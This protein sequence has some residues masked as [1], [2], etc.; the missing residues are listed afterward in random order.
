MPHWSTY[1]IYSNWLRQWILPSQSCAF[2]IWHCPLLGM[3]LHLPTNDYWMQASS[4]R[5]DGIIPFGH[6]I[7]FS[8]LLG[9]C[10]PHRH[11]SHK[12]TAIT[13]HLAQISLQIPLQTPFRLYY[14]AY[15]FIVVVGLIVAHIIHI[16]C[17]FT[18]DSVFLGYSVTAHRRPLSNGSRLP[19]W[20]RTS[21]R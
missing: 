16:R 20:G 10:F 19:A 5:W 21:P 1:Y 13:S 3:P 11:I 2:Q 17:N 7:N 14:H 12:L 9:W 8:Y 6:F 15:V 18:P 4:H